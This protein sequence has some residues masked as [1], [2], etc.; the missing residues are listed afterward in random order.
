MDGARALSSN[1]EHGDLP[2][3]CRSS[4]GLLFFAGAATALSLDLVCPALSGLLFEKSECALSYEHYE[5]LTAASVTNFL[6]LK[7]FLRGL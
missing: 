2:A 1:S 4:S 3:G 6:G 5:A 7:K